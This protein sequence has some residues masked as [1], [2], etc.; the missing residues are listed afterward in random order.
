MLARIVGRAK[1]VT[2][3]SQAG[4]AVVSESGVGPMVAVCRHDV[5]KARSRRHK[6]AAASV[7]GVRVNESVQSGA[8]ADVALLSRPRGSPEQTLNAHESFSAGRC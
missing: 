3:S 1:K 5:H 4:D 8:D 2:E 6:A 7:G